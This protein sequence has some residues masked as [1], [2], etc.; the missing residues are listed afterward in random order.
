MLTESDLSNHPTVLMPPPK[1]TKRSVG[2][3]TPSS[4]ESKLS[5]KIRSF[6][7]RHYPG[8]ISVAVQKIT[9]SPGRSIDSQLNQLTK[10]LRLSDHNV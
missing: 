1:A 9:L 5:I 7:I 3:Q 10:D 6:S 4:K 2:L 8:I